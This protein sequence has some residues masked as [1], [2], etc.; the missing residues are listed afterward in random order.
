MEIIRDIMGNTIHNTEQQAPAWTRAKTANPGEDDDGPQC[1]AEQ[2]DGDPLV[3]IEH[4]TA[5]TGNN[6]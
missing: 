2:L 6:N 4:C 5:Q 3:P 1:H